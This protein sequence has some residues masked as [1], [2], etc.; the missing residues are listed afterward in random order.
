MIDKKMTREQLG[1]RKALSSVDLHNAGGSA[2]SANKT[3]VTIC[4][5]VRKSG[6][7]VMTAPCP[8]CGQYAFFFNVR[9]EDL[10]LLPR[11]NI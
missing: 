2:I 9:R 7:R 3:V 10:T 8:H 1:G 5:V 4:D 6:I 11:E